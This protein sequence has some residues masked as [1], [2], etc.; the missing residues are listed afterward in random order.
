MENYITMESEFG[1]WSIS[2]NLILKDPSKNRKYLLINGAAVIKIHVITR[3][4]MRAQFVIAWTT[5]SM[6]SKYANS[7]QIPE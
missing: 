1:S 3:P 6:Y 4:G 7:P 5:L 2:L